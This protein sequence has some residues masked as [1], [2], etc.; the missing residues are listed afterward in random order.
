MTLSTMTTSTLFSTILA[1]SVA[2][3]ILSSS[4]AMA[5]DT[6][7][8][9]QQRMA[10]TAA[11]TEAAYLIGPSVASKL[12]CEIVWQSTVVLPPGIDLKLVS[13]TPAATLALNG[14]NEVTFLRSA[15]GDSAWTA[16]AALA[17][18]HV[19]AMG[20]LD[21]RFGDRGG[22]VAI[23]TDTQLYLLNE[24][25]GELAKKSSYRHAPSTL[26]VLA[27]EFVIFG[28]R[29]G[30]LVFVNAHTGFLYRSSVVDPVS[31]APSPIAARPATDGAVVVVGSSTG[32]IAAY[33]TSSAQSIWRREL[34]A[35]IVA[36]P[37]ISGNTVF[38]ASEDQYLYA[39]DLG[40]GDT[41][42]KYFTQTPLRTPPFVAGEMV[43][44]EI[45]GE[46]LVAFTANPEGQVGGQVRWKKTGI[47]GKPISTAMSAGRESV[48]F[49]C[50]KHRRVS[51]VDLLKG[52]IIAQVDLPKVQHLEADR[53]DV[54]GFVAWSADGRIERLAPV[55]SAPVAAAANAPADATSSESKSA[56]S[57]ESASNG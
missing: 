29:N 34:L 40:N 45:P 4:P 42:W 33:S 56:T 27:N 32:T 12:G 21:D 52:D 35:G 47:D 13:A 23:F 26:P 50:P 51:Y 8:A 22:R 28:S 9:A 44:Q 31:R 36:S 37:A 1:T 17:I 18:D 41:L 16:S 7:G 14:R 57:D 5:D 3:A 2:A 54:G 48:V 55:K 11:K 20:V 53:L 38:V 39:L 6:A 19:D 43:L 25:D 46:G 15:N 10:E 30:Q 49:W 24:T